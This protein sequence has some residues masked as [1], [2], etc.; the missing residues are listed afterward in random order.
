M[1]PILVHELK[2]GDR[3][4]VVNPIGDAVVIRISETKT[5]CGPGGRQ[6][7]S[8][9]DANAWIVD[10]KMTTGIARGRKEHTFQHPND[11]IATP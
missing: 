11:R 1:N 4:R 6:P 2:P 10:F 7:G 3:I 8:P 5:R 9:A